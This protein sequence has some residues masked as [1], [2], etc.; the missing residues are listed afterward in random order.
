MQNTVAHQ[1]IQLDE[2]FVTIPLDAGEEASVRLSLVVRKDADPAEGSFC[3]LRQLTDANIYLGCFTDRSG[4][5]LKW[6]EL[7]VRNYDNIADKLHENAFDVINNAVLDERWDRQKKIL[8]LS[9][10]SHVYKTSL[11][12][13]M[14]YSLHVDI[15]N[16]KV[17]FVK[18]PTSKIHWKI[19]KEDELLKRLELAP[20]STSIH[21]YLYLESLGADSYF[22]PITPNAPQNAKT[23][24]IDEGI[25]GRSTLLPFNSYGGSI[26]VRE[27]APMSLESYLC[28]LSGRP[29]EGVGQGKKKL[30]PNGVYKEI[31]DEV[32]VGYAA[33]RLVSTRQGQRTWKL[34]SL[35]LKVRLFYE[36]IS[37]VKAC[38]EL[39]QKPFFALEPSSFGICLPSTSPTAPFLWDAEVVMNQ[40]SDAIAFSVEKQSELDS[41]ETT[42]FRTFRPLTASIY[43]PEALAQHRTLMAEVTLLKIDRDRDTGLYEISGS[44]RSSDIQEHGILGR[45]FYFI[46]Y[47]VRGKRMRLVAE[48][49]EVDARVADKIQFRTLKLPL[50]SEQQLALESFIG[51]EQVG[52]YCEIFPVLGTP[53]DLYSLGVIGLEV[54]FHGSEISLAQLKDQLRTL[55]NSCIDL[56]DELS[57]LERIAQT[58]EAEPHLS[59]TLMPDVLGL[60][61]SGKDNMGLPPE[62]RIWEG[63]LSVIMKM[64]SGLLKSE[65]YAPSLSNENNFRMTHVF[66]QPLS[67]LGRYMAI[68]RSL[69]LGDTQSTR[70]VGEVLDEMIMD[71]GG[72]R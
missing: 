39:D 70:L 7:W 38:V 22:L 8:E 1:R 40:T 52:V 29:W 26:M 54:L 53:C 35:F 17:G 34:E 33:G 68:L 6:L 25:G 31:S 30:I 24:S 4:Y 10:A 69:N 28:V 42:Y 64:L 47:S 3:R 58:F 66:D 2:E 19:C 46:D 20:Y 56:S 9:E 50:S 13:Q 55:A 61:Q 51:V 62:E 23:K 67:E 41:R 43:R 16:K 63:L 57:L 59:E 32:S 49:T 5:I 60:A 37:Q 45:H 21:R 36:M 27:V 15:Y 72:S 71:M 11:D 48:M 14:E 65:S 18:D 44:M 12:T